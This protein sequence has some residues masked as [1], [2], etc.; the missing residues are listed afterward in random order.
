M[1]KLTQKGAQDLKVQVSMK[2]SFQGVLPLDKPVG[3]VSFKMISLLRKT[4]QVKTIGHAGTLDPFA[5]GILLIMIGKDYTRLSNKLMSTSKTYQTTLHLGIET[6]T[7]DLDG[8]V[9]SSH[10]TLPTLKSIEECIVPFQG[11]QDQVPP[12]FSAKS[13]NG[14]KLYKLARK[15]I[16]IERPPSRVYM[17]IEISDYNAPFLSLTVTC[18]KGTYIR[19]LARDLGV[20]LG[21][22]AHLKQLRRTQCGLFNLE[23]AFNGELLCNGKASPED[24]EKKMLKFDHEKLVKTIYGHSS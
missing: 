17:E 18:N 21:C 1:R 22:G 3:L 15:G 23:D 10:S 16:E 24:L 20:S 13:I 11:W 2:N 12:M 6:D 4:T 7:Y 9:T 14:Q 5:T 19:S 8:K